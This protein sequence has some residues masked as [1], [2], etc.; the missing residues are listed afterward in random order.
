MGG[1]W[2][3]TWNIVMFILVAFFFGI[4]GHLVRLLDGLEALAMAQLLAAAAV[5]CAV[6]DVV[7]GDA[8]VLLG[9]RSEVLQCAW[10]LFCFSMRFPHLCV[11]N[12]WSK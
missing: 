3:S 1:G 4:W 6:A 11:S 8:L 9:P 7:A 12:G 2:F 10:F 5:G